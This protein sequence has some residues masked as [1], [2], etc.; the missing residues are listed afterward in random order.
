MHGRGRVRATDHKRLS[1]GRADT[2]GDGDRRSQRSSPGPGRVAPL[3]AES[4]QDAEHDTG[5]RLSL[6]HPALMSPHLSRQPVTGNSLHELRP[7]SGA[8]A[9]TIRRWA[10]ANHVELPKRGRISQRIIDQFEAQEDAMALALGDTWE[11]PTRRG[12]GK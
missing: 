12:S 8:C 7:N 10:K 4:E 3:A 1:A 6:A 2:R 5:K 9:L 11:S